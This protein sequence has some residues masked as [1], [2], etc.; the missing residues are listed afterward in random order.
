M[1][2]ETRVS[3]N[4]ASGQT[5]ERILGLVAANGGDPGH[6]TVE[7]LQ[8]FDSMHLGGW[9]AT[10]L[11]L[12]ALAV[13]PGETVLD[14]GCGIGAASRTAARRGAQV[15]GIDLTPEFV[16]VAVELTRRTGTTGASFREGSA[17]SLPFPDRSFDAAIMLHVGMN[18]PDKGALFAEVA[19]V[20][21]PGGR[22]G[23]YDVMRVGSGDL[24]YPMPWAGTEAISFVE[25]PDTYAERAAAAGF[26]ETARQARAPEALTFLDDLIAAG[27]GRG[28]P[29][30]RAANIRAAVRDGT[31]APVQMIFTLG[32]KDDGNG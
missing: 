4:Y 11:L 30:D 31:L 27:P 28:M 3:A 22:F 5:L 17:L 10:E 16:T 12:D 24:A 8:P 29:P 25:T 7:A 1:T 13:R 26:R 21:R 2:L 19:R 23:V 9:R 18:I 15:E 6:L 32:V 20:L 14:I